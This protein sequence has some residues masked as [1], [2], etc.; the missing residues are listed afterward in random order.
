MPHT[1]LSAARNRV[2]GSAIWPAG[3]VMRIFSSESIATDPTVRPMDRTPVLVGIGA[4]VRRDDELA[5]L[6][7]LGMMTVAAEQALADAGI[8]GSRVGAVIVPRGLWQTRDPGRVVAQ[9]LG[10]PDAHTVL[11]D[12]GIL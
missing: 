6:D 1:S 3:P 5:G 7:H 11:A 2:S 9:R 10:A 8:D 12:L 4:E